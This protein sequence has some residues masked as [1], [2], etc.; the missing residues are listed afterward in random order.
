MRVMHAPG[1][2]APGMEP[3][4]YDTAFTEN[5]FMGGMSPAIPNVN[6]SVMLVV[7][8]SY[9]DVF[10]TEIS[11]AFHFWI[12]STGKTGMVWLQEPVKLIAIPPIFLE[13]SGN[14]AT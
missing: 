11:E 5:P 7:T 12:L 14:S 3:Y 4:I 8:V 1:D 2:I 6:A 13:Q 9:K 10:K